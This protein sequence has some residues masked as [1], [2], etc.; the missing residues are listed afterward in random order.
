MSRTQEAAVESHYADASLERRLLDALAAVGKDVE[1]LTHED[2]SL[3]DEFHVGGRRATVEF[4]AHAPV[5]P[6]MRL[7]DVGCGVGG[8]ARY[9]A[10]AQGCDVTGIDLTADF[11]TVA[12]ALAARV[13]LGDKARYRQASALDMPF[14]A[15]SFDGAYMLHVGM[16]I[17]DKAA[18]FAEA[19]RVLKPGG[20]FAVYDVMRAG[21]GELRFPVPWAS[22]PACSFL[23]P[24]EAYRDAAARA[25]FRLKSKRDRG[26][27]ARQV[28]AA[29]AEA[30]PTLTP[31][32]VLVTPERGRNLR[33]NLKR[34]VISPVEMVF[35]AAAE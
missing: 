21:E 25:G 14:D 24:P 31:P 27:F 10:A 34:G 26:E 5:R 33:E 28:F 3:V 23:A 18:L 15:G 35:E 19:R 20:F 8:P 11:V 32:P 2:L 4:A 13:G 22:D 16:N 29:I 7:L 30:D 9:F 6:G 1:R 17:E 12:A